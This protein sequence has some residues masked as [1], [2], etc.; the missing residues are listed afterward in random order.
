[1]VAVRMVQPTT[2]VDIE[3]NDCHAE[4]MEETQE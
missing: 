1:M 3:L 2:L 4:L